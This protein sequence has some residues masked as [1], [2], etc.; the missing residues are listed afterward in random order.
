MFVIK[1]Q[2]AFFL[3]SLTD[4]KVNK[5]KINIVLSSALIM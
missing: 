5:F 4:L 2:N 3:N 1:L